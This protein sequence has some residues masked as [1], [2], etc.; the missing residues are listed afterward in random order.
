MFAIDYG[1]QLCCLYLP[2]NYRSKANEQQS[3]SYQAKQETKFQDALYCKLLFYAGAIH[4][5][6][7]SL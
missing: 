2:N 1:A 7:I 4:S 3:L 6:A 5:T